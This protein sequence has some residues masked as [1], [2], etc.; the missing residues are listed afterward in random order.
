MSK[1]DTIVH[2]ATSDSSVISVAKEINDTVVLKVIQE[3]NSI[4]HIEQNAELL[5]GWLVL[6]IAGLGIAL[7]FLTV[8]V[9]RYIAPFFKTKYKI[10]SINILWY[11]ISVIIWAIYILFAS[12]LFIKSSLVLSVSL[13]TLI[14]LVGHQFLF[15][16]F[17]GIYFRFEN[18]IRIRDNFVYDNVSGEITKFGVRHLK[19][20][21]TENEIVLIPYRKLLNET[22]KITKQVDNLKRK[23]ISIE[24]DGP[25]SDNIARLENQMKR[26]PWIYNPKNYSITYHEDQVYYIHLLAKEEF[27]FNKVEAYLQDKNPA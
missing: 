22:I 16:F 4:P 13:L 18:Q 27:T 23:T 24:L 21:N 26:C 20:I 8:F 19:I 11:R 14:I 17:I 2:N 1:T 7:F 25:V 5:S 15:D 6:F 10:T 3:S 12:Y 9:K